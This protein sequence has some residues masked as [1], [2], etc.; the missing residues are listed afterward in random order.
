MSA[1]PNRLGKRECL[2]GL[3]LVGLRLADSTPL[4]L[5]LNAQV[6]QQLDPLDLLDK[7]I[8]HVDSKRDDVSGIS[9]Q[10]MLAMLK[11]IGLELANISANAAPL[12]HFDNRRQAEDRLALRFCA[13]PRLHRAAG[14]D[15]LP[16]EQSWRLAIQQCDP[17]PRD[18][19]ARPDQSSAP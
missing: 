7:Q 4:P 5:H 8:K 19:P 16:Q 9:P 17:N 12:L 15:R 1:V 6:S 13:V 10:V 18:D 2:M 3:R 11:G 14:F